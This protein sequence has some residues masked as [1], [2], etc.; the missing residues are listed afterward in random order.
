MSHS[1]L[2]LLVVGAG[3]TALAI[4]A[5]ARGAA[6]DVLLVERGALTQA[7]LDYPVNMTFFTT[8]RSAGDRR[9]AV[10]RAGTT[11]PIASRRWS[12]T[13]AFASRHALPLALH[14]EV[15]SVER[16]GETFRVHTRRRAGEMQVREA[17]AVAIATGYFGQPRRLACPARIF[18]GFRRATVSPIRTGA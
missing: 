9:R 16:A 7:M 11:S 1:M 3:P 14:E 2:D 12:T 4:G 15:L 6:M 8:P 13:A 10:R 17:R 5:D 18:P